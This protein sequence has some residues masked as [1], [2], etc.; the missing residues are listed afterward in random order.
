V[1]LLVERKCNIDV[2]DSDNSTALIKVDSSQQFQQ[3]VDLIL[4]LRIK[5]NL[6][7]E[8]ELVKFMEC[9][10]AILN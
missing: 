3:E 9:L 7:T 5:M 6:L 2:C 4:M 1:T 8:T 10:S